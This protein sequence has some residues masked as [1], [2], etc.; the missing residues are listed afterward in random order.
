MEDNLPDVTGDSIQI[1][2]VLLNLMQNSIEAMTTPE[3]RERIL[4]VV[5]QRE[6][7]DLIQITVKD[8]GPGL[9]A[10]IIAYIFDPHY[11]PIPNGRV[12]VYV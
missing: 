11:T 4:T 12:W 1:M 7:K 2:Q 3:L 6:S 8:T 5:T 9:D 10:K